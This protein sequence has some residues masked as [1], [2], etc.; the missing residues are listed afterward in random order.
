MPATLPES[1]IERE[2]RSIVA[3]GRFISMGDLGIALEQHFLPEEKDGRMPEGLPDAMFSAGCWLKKF[4]Y[5]ETDRSTGYEHVMSGEPTTHDGQRSNMW[6][7]GQYRL[8]AADIPERN[9]WVR[10][11]YTIGTYLQEHPG[12][13]VHTPFMHYKGEHQ[14]LVYIVMDNLNLVSLEI[15]C[16]EE[17]QQANRSYREQLE[18]LEFLGIETA[19]INPATNCGWSHR[20]KVVYFFDFATPQLSERFTRTKTD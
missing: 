6:I 3:A 16:G 4:G 12:Q 5:R 13:G 8:K 7:S 19:D 11:E 20:E 1:T 14:G 9:Q 15:L 18:K 10:N 17:R 2:M